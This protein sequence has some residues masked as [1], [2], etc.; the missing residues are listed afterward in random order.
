MNAKKELLQHLNGRTIEC[1]EIYVQG[2]FDWNTYED[3]YV[4]YRLT[5]GYTQEEYDEFL[6]Q[7][8]KVKYDDGPGGQ[9]LFG[10]VFFTDGSWL[11]RGEYDGS[12]WWNN[13][14]RIVPDSIKS[15]LSTVELAKIQSDL[16]VRVPTTEI[17]RAL[18]AKGFELHEVINFFELMEKKEYELCVQMITNV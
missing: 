1:A 18:T 17:L 16:I 5:Q 6:E 9:E 2:E 15:S 10:E 4:Y 11:D 3:E 8:N 7:L 13:N 14:V 12:E